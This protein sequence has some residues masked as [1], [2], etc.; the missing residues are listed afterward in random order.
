MPRSALGSPAPFSPKRRFPCREFRLQQPVLPLVLVP[1]AT[2]APLAQLAEQ[3]TL[4]H[5]VVGSIPT[6]CKWLDGK[7][8]Q[9]K[10]K[11]KDSYCTCFAR[12]QIVILITW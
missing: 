5:W 2:H 6:R 11:A 1:V 10:N 3:V 9:N 7:R 8:L 4:N 12:K